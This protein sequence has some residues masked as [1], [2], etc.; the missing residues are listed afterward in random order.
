MLVAARNVKGEPTP[1]EPGRKD[2]FVVEDLQPGTCYFA[3]C[4]D[5]AEMNQSDMSNVVEVKVE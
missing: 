4:S 5:D 3:I 2:K 1:S